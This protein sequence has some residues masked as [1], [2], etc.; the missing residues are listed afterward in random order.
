ME[1]RK[2]T[3]IK[4]IKKILT[5]E[6]LT[7]EQIMALTKFDRFNDLERGTSISLRLSYLTTLLN[8]VRVL[9]LVLLR[10]QKLQTHT[11]TH[12][13][14]ITYSNNYRRLFHK[15]LSKIVSYEILERRE[16]GNRNPGFCYSEQ[17]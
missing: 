7:S 11:P 6:K 4:R 12:T 1:N 14:T 9:T 2:A 3:A 15:R 5:N 17:L 10:K 13:N 8:A 16:N